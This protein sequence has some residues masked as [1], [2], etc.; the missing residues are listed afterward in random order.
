MSIF[1]NLLNCAVIEVALLCAQKGGDILG[2]GDESVEPKELDPLH[3]SPVLP[4][5]KGTIPYLVEMKKIQFQ[6]P[7][8]AIKRQDRKSCILEQNI[9]SIVH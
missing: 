5:V 9:F 7:P 2:K 3:R 6:R 1:D 4:L 8:E